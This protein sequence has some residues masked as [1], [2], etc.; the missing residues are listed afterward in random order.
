MKRK[1]RGAVYDTEVAQEITQWES[2]IEGVNDTLYRTKSGKY[3]VCEVAYVDDERH[4]EAGYEYVISPVSRA[5]AI[6]RACDTLGVEAA[7]PL[8]QDSRDGG[9]RQLNAR[10]SSRTHEILRNVAAERGV[11]IGRVIEELVNEGEPFGDDNV[12]FDEIA[13]RNKLYGET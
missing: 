2:V 10:V 12:V 3:F 7:R 8:F 4:E 6:R 5:D 1:I 11:S 13:Q 9:L